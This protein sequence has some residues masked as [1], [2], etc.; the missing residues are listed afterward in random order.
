MSFFQIVHK[1]SK[2]PRAGYLRE[3]LIYGSTK[4]TFSSSNSLNKQH[5]N[6]PISTSFVKLCNTV[7][8]AQLKTP[9][10]AAGK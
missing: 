9:V 1:A 10:V 6:Q 4:L 7:K 2:S 5:V 8:M 3:S